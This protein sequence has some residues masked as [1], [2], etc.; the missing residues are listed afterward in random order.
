MNHAFGQCPLVRMWWDPALNAPS[1]ESPYFNTVAKHDYNVGYDFN[2]E[3]EATKNFRDRVFTYWLN[4]Y[5]V[6]GYRFDLSKGF[7]QNNTLGDVGAWGAY[8]ASRI[9]IWKI[10]MIH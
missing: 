2:H 8:D 1:A 9:E 6:D 3:S 4:E 10:F 5:N 7:T